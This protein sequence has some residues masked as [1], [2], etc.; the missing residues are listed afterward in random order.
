MIPTRRV[1]LEEKMRDLYIFS[2]LRKLGYDINDCYDNC[3]GYDESKYLKCVEIA[4]ECLSDGKPIPENVVSY[5]L[6]VKAI[7]EKRRLH[8][9]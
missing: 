4:T 3:V 6:K 7:H 1:S 9:K 5:M 2:E 8:S